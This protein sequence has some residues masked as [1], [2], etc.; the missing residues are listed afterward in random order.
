MKIKCVFKGG[1][2]IQI[3]PLFCLTNTCRQVTTQQLRSNYE[4]ITEMS[5]NQ[6]GLRRNMQLKVRYRYYTIGSRSF[7][8]FSWLQVVPILKYCK[9]S[10]TYRYEGICL[11]KV[12]VQ[13]NFEEFTLLKYTKFVSIFYVI[14]FHY[15]W[16]RYFQDVIK[17]FMLNYENVRKN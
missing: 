5:Q 4:I 14:N 9:V 7:I 11:L 15:S 17:I 6:A 10:K 12:I 8:I 3:F 16:H 1:F 2:T 13:Y